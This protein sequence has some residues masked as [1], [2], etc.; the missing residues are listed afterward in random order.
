[1]IGFESLL[2][3]A[4]WVSQCP[5]MAVFETATCRDCGA[6]PNRCTTA[7]WVVLGLF[8]ICEC[9]VH[10]DRVS[11]QTR[12]R[13]FRL[14]QRS[15]NVIAW[16]VWSWILSVPLKILHSFF[17][18]SILQVVILRSSEYDLASAYDVAMM[19]TLLPLAG[20]LQR[21]YYAFVTRDLTPF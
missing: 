2:G 19:N 9:K 18:S 3:K 7:R 1:M 21:A 11:E 13:D 16:H 20:E 5:R 12:K 10:K 14:Q 6:S 4:V 15:K 17:A 8:T